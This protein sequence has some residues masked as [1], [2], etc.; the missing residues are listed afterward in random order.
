MYLLI[1]LKNRLR[2]CR[3]TLSV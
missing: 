2:N 3:I 1:T